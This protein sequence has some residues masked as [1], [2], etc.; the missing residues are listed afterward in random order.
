ME[1]N[2]KHVLWVEAYRP[3]TIEECILP[4]RLKVPFKE[5]VKSGIIPNLLLSGSAGVGKTT[6]ARALCEEVGC[7]YLV[8]NGSDESGI[9]TFR[10]KIKNYASSLSMT[11]GRKVI[12]IDESDYLNPNS[13]QP[14]LR[15]AM[16]EFAGNC[17]FIF[18]CNHKNRIIEPLHSR[19]A[20]VDFTL[21]RK[22]QQAMAGA[23]FTRVKGILTTEGIDYETK[24]LAEIVSKF[25]PDFRRILNELQRLSQFGKI[26]V[27]VLSQLGELDL[28]QIVGY[29]KAKDFAALRKWVGSTDIEPV[30][31]YR[32]LYDNLYE[33]L[34]K[35]SIPQAILLLADYQFKGMN[36]ADPQINT[37]ALLVELMLSCEFI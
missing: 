20:C 26:D 22:E 29:L 7:D 13:T 25:L 34:K 8:I 16:E 19:C 9:D 18:T 15:G 36:A 32:K 6:V 24:V 10:T 21:H 1:T 5:Y 23:F 35:E 3:A 14:A 12:I 37:M 28:G 30:V 11:G 31:L 33:V 2:L 27:G 4:D 17:S